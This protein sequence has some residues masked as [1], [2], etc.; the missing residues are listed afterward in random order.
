MEMNDTTFQEA[1]PEF[2]SRLAH[3]LWQ[4]DGLY[5]EWLKFL[6]GLWRND[7]L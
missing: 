5:S 4:P 7:Y 1:F 6:N 2:P 3:D